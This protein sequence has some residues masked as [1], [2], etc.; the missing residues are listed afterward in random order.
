MLQQTQVSRVL[1]KYDEFLRVFPTVRALATAPTGRILRAWQGLGYNRRA[2]LLQKAAR[3]VMSDFG[4]R[5]P[6]TRDGLES[7]PGVG[8]STA[9]AIMAFAFGLP[10]VFI[11][12]NI[13]SVFLHFFFAGRR[14]V[15]DRDI[16]PL[17]ERTLPKNTG[18]IGRRAGRGER[19]R[20]DIRQWYYAL[21]DYGVH[22]KQTMPNPSR[23]SAHHARQSPFKGSNRQVRA[24]ILRFILSVGA[25]GR[26]TAAIT[27]HI[28]ITMGPTP[29]DIRANIAALAREGFIRETARGWRA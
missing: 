9:G 25:R 2:I 1:S 23:R 18:R 22:L 12:T 21:M 19:S 4:G 13:R 24:E 8:Q 15:H 7:L 6:R 5:F 10:T 28:A 29:H 27:R 14:S 26:T 16:L 3:A 20:L 11:E 17:I